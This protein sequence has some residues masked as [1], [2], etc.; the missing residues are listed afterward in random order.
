MQAIRRSVKNANTNGDVTNSNCTTMPRC[1]SRDN[2]TFIDLCCS[3]RC[4]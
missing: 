3:R 1:Y 2:L 4:M